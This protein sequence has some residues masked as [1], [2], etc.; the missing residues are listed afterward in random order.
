MPQD[1]AM[2]WKGN[3]MFVDRQGQGFTG[4]AMVDM[5]MQCGLITAALMSTWPV[6]VFQCP[7]QRPLILLQQAQQNAACGEEKVYRWHQPNL[8]PRCRPLA[9]GYF[10]KGMLLLLTSCKCSNLDLRGIWPMRS[11]VS[12]TAVKAVMLVCSA[13]N[14]VGLEEDSPAQGI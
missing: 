2:L 10:W 13:L 7:T 9:P 6:H 8:A 4:A 12:Q 14:W 3:E 11:H 5:P 1:I